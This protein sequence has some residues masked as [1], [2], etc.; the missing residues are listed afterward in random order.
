MKK[1]VIIS[2][3]AFVAIIFTNCSNNSDGLEN[4]TK[5]DSIAIVARYEKKADS[6][7]KAFD[8]EKAKAVSAQDTKPLI[9]VGEANFKKL[10]S[11]I[12][13]KGFAITERGVACDR[14]YNF[15]DNQ[16][17]LHMMVA[18]KRDK[19]GNPSIHGTV[20]QISVWAYYNGIID[21]KHFFGY[22]ITAKRAL[23]FMYDKEYIEGN[24]EAV[25]RGYYGMLAKASK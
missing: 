14:Q 15:T 21:Q 5:A 20:T 13:G 19:D 24:I 2:V 6:L 3:V 8:S 1:I 12:G 10:V 25:K 23:P 11:Y 16:G 18:I 9:P 17:T 7:K 4:K 22:D